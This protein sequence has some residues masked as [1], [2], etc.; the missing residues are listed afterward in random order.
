MKNLNQ[1]M[2]RAVLALVLMGVAGGLVTGC[3]WGGH[4]DDRGHGDDHHE[5]H[6]DDDH[7]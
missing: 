4:G 6:H 2:K 3:F 7:H 5:E 1:M